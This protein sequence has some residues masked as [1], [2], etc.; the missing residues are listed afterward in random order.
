MSSETP[1]QH[2]L[3]TSYTPPTGTESY[4]RYQISKNHI[5][6]YIILWFAVLDARISVS[7]WNY[8]FPVE[9]TGN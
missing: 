7:A 6:I 9:L 2:S 3:F 5:H 1:A 8:C 4:E